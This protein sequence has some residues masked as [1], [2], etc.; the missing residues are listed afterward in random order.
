MTLPR[1]ETDAHKTPAG[2]DSHLSDVAR[3]NLSRWYEH[4][5][6]FVRLC[7]ELAPVVNRA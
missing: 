3:A 6:G 4:D 1:D 5:L 7:Y 2:F